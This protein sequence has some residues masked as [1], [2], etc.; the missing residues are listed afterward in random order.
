MPIFA[1]NIEYCRNP[2]YGGYTKSDNIL[3]IIVKS[4]GMAAVA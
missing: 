4:E 1:K 3:K 2:P